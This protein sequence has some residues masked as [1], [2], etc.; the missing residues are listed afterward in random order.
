MVTLRETQ[1]ESGYWCSGD[2]ER[3]V[4]ETAVALLGLASVREDMRRPYV[5]LAA[6]WLVAAQREDGG[7]GPDLV[8]EPQR[9]TTCI[10]LLALLDAGEGRSVAAH[11]AAAWLS[12]HLEVAADDPLEI[13]AL[14]CYCRA[15]R[16][17]WN[18]WR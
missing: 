9:R 15:N 7:Y 17:R 5:Q 12:R 6:D 13:L 8:A 14:G 11:D 18:R 16:D 2:G 3:L 1:H 4:D 10:A